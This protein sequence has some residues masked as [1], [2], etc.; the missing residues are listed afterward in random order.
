MFTNL[1]FFFQFFVSF[2]IFPNSLSVNK[3]FAT[4][5][6]KTAPTVFSSS[7]SFRFC[8]SIFGTSEGTVERSCIGEENSV[9]I[10]KKWSQTFPDSFL[11]VDLCPN[12][13]KVQPTIEIGRELSFRYALSN[14]KE[15]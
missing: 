1:F 4:I 14:G 13:A 7:I 12:V 8:F 10:T 3:G 5:H 9:G 11:P 15:V 6:P 2:S